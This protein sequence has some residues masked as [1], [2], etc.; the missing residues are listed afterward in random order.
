MDKTTKCIKMLHNMYY[1]AEM[2]SLHIKNIM[3]LLKDL[4]YRRANRI[5]SVQAEHI[6]LHKKKK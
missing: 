3:Y 5:W 4:F 2:I 6:S 1:G